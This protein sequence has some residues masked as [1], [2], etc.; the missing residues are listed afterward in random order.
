MNEDGV[1]TDAAGPELQNKAVLKEGTDAGESCVCWYCG[2]F[3][4]FLC[5]YCK[6]AFSEKQPAVIFA[7]SSLNLALSTEAKSGNCI[8]FCHVV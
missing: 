8:L 2:F 7:D 6:Y 5:W 3:F 4:S 1:F